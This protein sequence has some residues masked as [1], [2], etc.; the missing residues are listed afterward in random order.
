M[1]TILLAGV[2]RVGTITVM[3]PWSYYFTT[4]DDG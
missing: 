4:H 3:V 1:G 2:S